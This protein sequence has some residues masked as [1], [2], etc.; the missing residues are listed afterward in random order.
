M[1]CSL[2]K[3]EME[4]YRKG[5]RFTKSE[6]KGALCNGKD[7]VMFHVHQ[8]YGG[9]SRSSKLSEREGMGK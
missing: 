2:T 7:A 3:G 8:K 4:Y 6:K 5:I 1:N 9:H